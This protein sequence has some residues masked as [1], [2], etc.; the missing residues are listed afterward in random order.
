MNV[1]IPLTPLLYELFPEANG[2]Q[3]ALVTAME[4]FYTVHGVKPK[5]SIEGEEVLIQV[6][7]ERIKGGD[8]LFREAVDLCEKGKLHDGMRS[9]GGSQSGVGA[10]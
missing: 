7:V 8:R 2:D 10:F 1:R 9:G 5:V 3:Q 4:A 6:D